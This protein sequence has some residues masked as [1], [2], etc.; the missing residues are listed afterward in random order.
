MKGHRMKPNDIVEVYED[1]I[2]KE[3]PEGK[4]RLVKEYRPD[5]GDGLSMWVVVFLDDPYKSQKLR[6]ISE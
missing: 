1:P 4:A 2:T 5:Y 6:T 3:R